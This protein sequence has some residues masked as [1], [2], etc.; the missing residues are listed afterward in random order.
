MDEGE[1]EGRLSN[2][3]N[4]LEYPIDFVRLI[5]STHKDD[6]LAQKF[7][8]RFGITNSGVSREQSKKFASPFRQ[9]GNLCLAFNFTKR[10]SQLIA[11]GNSRVFRQILQFCQKPCRGHS[12]PEEF[13]R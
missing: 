1:T 3:G 7:R 13:F 10:E 9:R 6:N 11:N 12:V 2:F 8:A 4:E 5:P